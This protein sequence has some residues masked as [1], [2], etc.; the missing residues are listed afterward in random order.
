MR[1]GRLLPESAPY[2]RLLLWL[3]LS[4]SVLHVG[5]T[6]GHFISTDEATVYEATQSLW[7][8]GSLTTRTPFNSAFVGR[9]GRFYGAYNAGQSV[10]ALP[11]YG[12]GKLVGRALDQ[13]GHETWYR[14]FA[15][16]RLED[17]ASRWAARS[18]SSSSTS[19]TASPSPC[20]TRSS[21]RS[22]FGSGPHHAG[23]W[24]PRPC[25]G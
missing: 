9:G 22:P 18:R 25:S 8:E 21:S 6:R 2:S 3:F 24:W 4:F 14:A 5:L 11:L 20:S 16:R 15:G 17:W 1:L 23:R 19:S 12:L 7:E 10:A 13:P